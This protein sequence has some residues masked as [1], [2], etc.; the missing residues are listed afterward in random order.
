MTIR[1]IEDNFQYRM[2]LLLKKMKSDYD[3][4]TNQ[5]SF[6]KWIWDN[7]EEFGRMVIDD[8][9]EYCGLDEALENEQ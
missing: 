2:H 7:A 1:T 9:E 5:T 6:D 3:V 8:I 4:D